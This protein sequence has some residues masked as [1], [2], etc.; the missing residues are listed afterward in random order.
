MNIP[1]LEYIASHLTL[2]ECRRLVASLHF[3]SFELPA[4]SES[5]QKIPKDMSCLNLIMK[6]NNGNEGKEKTHEHV[7]RRLRQ[8][9]KKDIADWLG[10]T[11]F[12][13]LAK[14]VEDAL[15]HPGFIGDEN[16]FNYQFVTFKDSDTIEIDQWN[17]LDSIM[18][19]MLIGIFGSILFTCWRYIMLTFTKEHNPGNEEVELLRK[20][21]SYNDVNIDEQI[22]DEEEECQSGIE[23]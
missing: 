22:A 23:R 19:I 6:W 10:V 1:E 7:A 11:V 13:N 9:G 4:L 16:K 3:V 20:L 18:Y 14:D 17:I 2:A 21:R 8:I 5:Q 12:H 15:L